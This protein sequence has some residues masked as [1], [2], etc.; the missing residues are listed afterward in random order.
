MK[1][2]ELPPFYNLGGSMAEYI[3]TDVKACIPLG[4]DLTLE[5]G[6][7]HFV[8]PLTALG[9][10]DRLKQL[11]TKTVIITAAA[12]QLSRM[13][14]KLCKM[15]GITPICTVRKEEQAEL[16]RNVFKCQNVVNTSEKN[17]KQT[18]GVMAMKLKPSACLECISADMT[19]TMCDFLGF[20]GTMILYGTLSE[21]PAGNINTIAF[22]G[23]NLKMEGYLLGVELAKM[24]LF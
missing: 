8:N 23:K 15:E 14:I 9:M 4:D 22:I 11:K 3:V 5:E 21:K 13:I 18:L 17:W 19:G 16:L 6:S 20:G 1:A 24:S 2:G 12:S 10:V 7:S